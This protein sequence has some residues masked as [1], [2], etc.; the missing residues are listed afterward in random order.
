MRFSDF[1][2]NP[3]FFSFSFGRGQGSETKLKLIFLLLQNFGEYNLWLAAEHGM[4][5]RRTKGSWMTTMPEN[6]QMDWVDSV[7]VNLQIFM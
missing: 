5:L 4:F 2:Y 3:F 6:L 1:I 7:K